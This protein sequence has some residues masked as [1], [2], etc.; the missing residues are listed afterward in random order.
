VRLD[1]TALLEDTSLTGTAWCRTYSDFT[2]T[3]LAKLLQDAA[4]SVAVH[5]VALAA[6]GGYGRAELC[7][8][9]DIDVM[10]LHTG[11]GDISAVADR[12]WY[13]IWDEGLKLGHSVR[14][15]KE[16][17]SLAQDDL[18]T[19]TALL[20]ARHLA[21]DTALTSDLAAGAAAQWQKRSKKWLSDLGRRVE[22]RHATAGEVAFHLEP[23]LKEGRGGLRDVHALDWAAATH[24][25]L[26]DS[27]RA[28]LDRA[29][30]VLLEARVELHR[31][32]GRASNVLAL[33]EQDGVAEALG[34]ESADTLMA[35]VAAAGRTIAWTSDEAWRQIESSLRGPLGRIAR[36]DRVVAP[37]I[38]LRDG[39]VHLVAEAV[40]LDDPVLVLRAAA[41][42]AGNDTLID[43]P[44]LDLLVRE[45]PTLPDPWPPEARDRLAEL[46]LA[47]R[48]AVR[49][50]EALDQRG[51]WVRVLPEWVTVR[52]KPQRNAYHRFTVDRHLVEAAANAAALAGRVS[53]PDLL[54]IGTLLHDI[55]KG[56][57]G[58]HTEVGMELVRVM[59]ARMGYPPEDVD[60]LVA[61]VQHHLLLPDVATRRDLDDPAT[62]ERVAEA[63]GTVER[64]HLL[65]ALTEADSLATGPAAWGSWKQGLVRTLEDRT[66]HVLGGGELGEMVAD[67]FPDERQRSL[68]ASGRQVIEGD[69]D[70]LTVIAGDRPGLFSRVAGV[71]ALH[72][73]GVLG[74]AAWSSEDGGALAV[75]TVERP[76]PRQIEWP[77]IIADLERALAG[78][79]ALNARLEER[80]NTYRS[81]RPAAPRPDTSVAFD[82]S[83]S[84]KATVVEVAAPD[85]VGLLYR[86]TRAL[87]ELD[88]DIR[89]AKVQTLG[90]Q[91]VDAFYVRD[92]VGQKLTDVAQQAEVE[93]AIRH[94]VAG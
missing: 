36:R 78:R 48:P 30:G 29:Y 9:S 21:G 28:D 40:P 51:L 52:S 26:F 89:S 59:G 23:D 6:V 47:G 39:D 67:E 65:A 72:G 62:I 85:S 34:R 7:P 81:R 55:G 11:R 13:P 61:L 46:L 14:T 10:L 93:R 60:T 80:A 58:D 54:V 32:T 37:G 77:K 4:G 91:V 19:A 8:E 43:R 92:G 15:V 70:V 42:A 44:S 79:L 87:A 49:V 66:A 24:R 45:A 88:L 74:A 68:V 76:H 90:A 35:E 27:D 83:A 12:V 71:L 86:L 82:N 73:L 18:D 20:S 17:L 64:L 3:W 75:F 69:D 53:R 84:A 5:G 2:D 41:I 16:A 33:Q 31:R 57:P 94:A 63:A 56:Y 22:E 25:V 50:I 1:R 38:A